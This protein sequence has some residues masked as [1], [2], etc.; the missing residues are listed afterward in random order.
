MYTD[1]ADTEAAVAT[2]T[3]AMPHIVPV[4]ISFF[5]DFL[6]EST[7]VSMLVVGEIK[8]FVVDVGF[9]LTMLT[10]E[11]SSLVIVTGAEVV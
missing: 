11:E 5:D 8:L 6:T 7:G 3:T 2:T 1:T 4:I 9:G 10:E